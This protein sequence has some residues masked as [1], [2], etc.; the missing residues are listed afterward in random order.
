MRKLFLLISILLFLVNIAGIF[1][2]N[3][4]EIRPSLQK[5]PIPGYDYPVIDKRLLLKMLKTKGNT[6][7]SLF[8][9]NACNAVYY[10]MFHSE[11]RRIT[12]FENW[13]MWL[14]GKIYQPLSH[15]QDAVLL[16]KGGA[17]NCNERAQVLMDIY[18]LNGLH[19]NFIMLNGHVTLQVFFKGRWIITDPDFGLVFNGS[20]KEMSLPAGLK[21][22]DSVLTKKG[23]SKYI[24]DRYLYF[25]G[26]TFDDIVLPLNKVSSS[27]L[28]RAEKISQWMRWIIPAVI[29]LICLTSFKK[30][31]F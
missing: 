26:V 29:V 17:G 10:G 12:F 7:D 23:F 6:G 31:A 21:Y 8:V 2:D 20:M 11:Q 22:I 18:K 1:L 4:I 3:T 25:W 19:S 15:T 30:K 28:Y 5:V 27:K 9:H 16:V 14:A 13:L 24:K